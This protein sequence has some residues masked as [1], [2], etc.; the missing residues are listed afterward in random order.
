[1]TEPKFITRETLVEAFVVF[2]AL[3]A[4]VA[5]AVAWGVL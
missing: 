4:I 3:L 1:M 2:A 5:C